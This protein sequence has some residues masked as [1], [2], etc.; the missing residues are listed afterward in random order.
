MPVIEAGAVDR[1]PYMPSAASGDSSRNGAPGSS[2]AG[3]AVARQQLA[4]RQVPL[5]RALRPAFRGLSAAR[6]ILGD[7][8]L[9][10]PRRFPAAR[11]DQAPRP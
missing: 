8:R 10:T 4:A 3:D 2:K 7:E 9:P 11:S 5:A 6:P 1:S